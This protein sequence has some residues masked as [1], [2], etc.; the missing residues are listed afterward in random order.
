MLENVLTAV[1]EWK[2]R[3]PAYDT[4]RAYYRGQ[5]ELK[6]MTPDFERKHGHLFSSLRENLCRAVVTAHTDRLNIERWGDEGAAAEAD[7]QGLGR[8]QGLVHREAFRCGD[9]YTLTWNGADGTPKARF[10]RADQIVPHVDELDPDRLDWAAKP[11]ITSDNFG[12]VNIYYAD[13]VERFRTVAKLAE[14]ASYTDMPEREQAWIPHSDD[15]GGDTIRHDFGAVPVCWWKHDADDTDGYGF[16]V[17]DDVIPLQDGLNKSLADLLVLSETHARPFWFLLNYKTPDAVAATNPYLPA[18]P[19]PAATQR[20]FDPSRQQIVTHDG[21]GPF[22]QL[23]PPDLRR[24][25][26]EQATFKDKIASVAGVPSYY[27]SQTSGQVPSGESLRVLTSRL[28]AAGSGF[29]QAA[30]PVWRGQGQLLGMGEVEPVW[31]DLMPMDE[32]ERI[33]NAEALSR[34]GLADEDVVAYLGLPD[35]ER[36]VERMAAGREARI[37]DRQQI[38]Y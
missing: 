8:L 19:Q 37:R 13:R 28:I 26:D 22:G 30:T 3:K 24:L 14:G 21:P 23:D 16:S 31:A 20:K 11:W 15:D 36:I 34:L 17:L 2:T 33:G 10:H 29:I 5:H 18:A 25:L 27:F 38:G 6:F 4:Y 12:R 9:A 35:A 7:D 32:T 1:K